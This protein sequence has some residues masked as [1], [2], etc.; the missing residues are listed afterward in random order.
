MYMY[1]GDNSEQKQPL[2]SG[3]KKTT[4]HHPKQQ[5]P[6]LRLAQIKKET[7]TRL[8]ALKDFLAKP[9][10]SLNVVG[11]GKGATPERTQ[12]SKAPKPPQKNSNLS[13]HSPMRCP[14]ATAV[15]HTCN[16]QQQTRNIDS[17]KNPRQPEA[18]TDQKTRRESAQPRQKPKPKEKQ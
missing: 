5:T 17:I 9:R 7:G 6:S 4:S 16:Q 12:N 1:P 15:V 2:Y 11:P 14:A 3:K 18:W 10:K 8:T 13:S